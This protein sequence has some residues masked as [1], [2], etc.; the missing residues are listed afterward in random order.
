M[1]T[2]RLITTSLK[3]SVNLPAT[4]PVAKVANAPTPK[5]ANSPQKG[6]L[7]RVISDFEGSLY[8][9]SKDEIL[10]VIGVS[11]FARAL[12]PT[13]VLRSQSTSAKKILEMSPTHL[14]CL[15]KIA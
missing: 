10:E 9:F 13:V 15:S 12:H 4:T 14:A 1:H 3:K 2:N 11:K 7:Y 5:T 8:S 6:S